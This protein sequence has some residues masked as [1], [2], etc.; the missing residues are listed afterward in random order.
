MPP[1]SAGAAADELRQIADLC[2]RADLPRAA[3]R[4]RIL[5]AFVAHEPHA[6]TDKSAQASDDGLPVVGAE[7]PAT[8]VAPNRVESEH[9]RDG[10][11]SI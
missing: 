2:D 5:A 10:D 8:D 6:L 1:A 7:A 4:L 9:P 3:G 11:D